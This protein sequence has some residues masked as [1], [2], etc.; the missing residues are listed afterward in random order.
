M[1]YRR[2]RFGSLHSPAVQ[3]KYLQYHAGKKTPQNNLMGCMWL[4]CFRDFDLKKTPKY[5]H[6]Q[7]VL[8]V[9]VDHGSIL[10]GQCIDLG[11]LL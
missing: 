9:S 3:S 4:H 10:Q 11:Q 6:I 7:Q 2:D 5:I 8:F 1:Q